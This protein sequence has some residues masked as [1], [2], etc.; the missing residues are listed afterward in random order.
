MSNAE[1][2]QTQLSEAFEK[3]IGLHTSEI[4]R[5]V[6][7]N[8][9]KLLTKLSTV[10]LVNNM[11]KKEGI[12]IKNSKGNEIMTKTIN[13][14]PNGKPEQSMSFEQIDFNNLIRE[15][16]E[17][18]TF[19]NK[20]INTIFLFVV[21]EFLE[22]KNKKSSREAVFK[23][24]LFWKMPLVTLDNHVKEMWEETKT[25]ISRGI[26]ITEVNRAN[27]IIRSNNLPG[28]AFNG[29]AH[30]R[31]KAKDGA[32]RVV[33]PDGQMLTRQA[34]WLNA[35]YIGEIVS[36]I[37]KS[38][39]IKENKVNTYKTMSGN[40]ISQ[41]KDMFREPIY[42]INDFCEKANNLINNFEEDY[43]CNNNLEKFAY[44]I[45]PHYV[46]STKYNSTNEY[47]DNV[48]FEKDYFVK[49]NTSIYN[50][51]AF[52]RRL[53]NL[54]NRYSLIKIE[55]D[56][57]ITNR[58]L[59]S[60]DVKVK[61]LI[62]YREKV[63][64]YIEEDRYFNL[65]SLHQKGFNHELESYGFENLFYESLLQ[66]PGRIKTLKI[67][68]HS[69]FIK[70]T[71]EIT[72]EDFINSFFEIDKSIKISQLVSKIHDIYDFEVEESYIIKLIEKTN[73]FYSKDLK[74]I[75]L[76]KD[77]FYNEIY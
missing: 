49:E 70:S 38:I 45:F 12:V 52:N 10:Q 55:D 35:S 14:E 51:G 3:Y 56:M 4:A 60:A 8:S 42:T 54:E 9:S 77:D 27:G 19:R 66:R 17:N 63:E 71:R 74:K 15:D 75:Y 28:I 21:F 44:R 72:A 29:I 18:S 36:S 24:V 37:P 22:L 20:F 47:F 41:F 68:K 6:N 43:F 76:D 50:T 64:K 23:G 26:E 40:Q 30:V 25:V 61:C 58:K 31:P 48:I 39:H 62:D 53:V 16:W 59:Q 57:Y 1:F 67:F 5:M 13:L 34:F 7:L 32:D 73:M 65:F 33:L 69:L 11:F 2:T 46:L